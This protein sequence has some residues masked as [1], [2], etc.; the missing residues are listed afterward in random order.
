MFALETERG[1]P[2]LSIDVAAAEAS[3]FLVLRNLHKASCGVD[4][5][6]ILVWKGRLSF[7]IKETS[8]QIAQ[9]ISFE[10]GT[11]Y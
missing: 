11:Y 10:Q 5:R 6:V 3:S 7:A 1:V 4:V 2:L 9:G 8:F